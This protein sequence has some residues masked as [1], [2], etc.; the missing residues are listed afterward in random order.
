MKHKKPD[1][2][3]IGTDGNVF[4]LA[5]KVQKVLIENDMAEQASDMVVELGKCKDYDE[6]LVLFSKYVDIE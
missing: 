5:A 6:A 4:A 3:L 1:C 2:K